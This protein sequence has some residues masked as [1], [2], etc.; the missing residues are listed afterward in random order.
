MEGRGRGAIGSF[1]SSTAGSRLYQTILVNCVKRKS[2]T[3]IFFS[4]VI[5]LPSYHPQVPSMDRVL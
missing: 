3:G 5:F 1:K 2:R 4:L